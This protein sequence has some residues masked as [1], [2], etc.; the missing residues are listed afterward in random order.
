[1]PIYPQTIPGAFGI[2][3]FNNDFWGRYNTIPLDSIPLQLLKEKFH[4]P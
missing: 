2:S 4:L 3:D 1:M